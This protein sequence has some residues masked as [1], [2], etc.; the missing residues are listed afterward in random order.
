MIEMDR[1]EEIALRLENL[2]ASRPACEQGARHGDAVVVDEGADVAVS[3]HPAL[4][5]RIGGPAGEPL[6]AWS[7]T[8]VTSVMRILWDDPE[9]WT[10]EGMSD[11][12]ARARALRA[13]RSAPAEPVI[14]LVADASAP[15][16]LG[17]PPIPESA[18]P[19]PRLSERVA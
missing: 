2:T 8:L 3:L 11:R 7:N 6:D 5:T 1:L 15:R 17:P 19:Q 14:D 12:A 18:A 13:Q 9:S 16:R 10:D 4:A